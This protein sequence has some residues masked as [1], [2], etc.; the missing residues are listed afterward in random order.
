MKDRRRF[1]TKCGGAVTVKTVDDVP[2]DVCTVCGAIFYDNPLPVVSTVVVEDRKVLLVL[3]GREPAA[4]LWCLPSGF[5]ELCETIEQAAL[6]ETLE[7]SGVK[8]EI[9]RMLDTGSHASDF[10]GDL[11]WVTFEVRRTGGELHAGDDACDAGFFPLDDLPPMAFETNVTA[12]KR[13]VEQY[14]DIWAMHDSFSKIEVGEGGMLSD[15]LFE[16]VSRDAD[17]ITRKWLDDV[18]AN[19]TTRTYG[20]G[21]RD[22]MYGEAHLVISQFGRWISHRGE[23]AEIREHLRRMGRDAKRAGLPLSEIVSA[24]SLTRKHIFARAFSKVRHLD[25]VIEQYRI[26]EMTSRVNLFYDKAVYD[27]IRGWEGEG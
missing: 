10:Y 9:V 1:C 7:E 12:I 2:R 23:D 8:G 24:L 27:L 25:G 6:R 14:R 17:L 15:T 26:L 19:P 13:F 20:H 16:I 21:S 22:R 4:G 3:R 5:V 18:T 11:I